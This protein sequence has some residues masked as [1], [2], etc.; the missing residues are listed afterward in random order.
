MCKLLISVVVCGKLYI[1]FHSFSLALWTCISLCGIFSVLHVTFHSFT[2][3]WKVEV[4]HSVTG[5]ILLSCNGTEL[6]SES[7]TICLFVKHSDCYN[8]FW[9]D[10]CFRL[11]MGE[12][13]MQVC[14]HHGLPLHK[15]LLFRTIELIDF[16][17]TPV[18]WLL[19]DRCLSWCSCTALIKDLEE[20]EL[21]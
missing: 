20:L 13:F 12:F 5:D 9:C 11:R 4:L 3:M 16:L 2:L 15:N 1:K 10:C 19:C 14:E 21:V 8:D 6:N 7:C 18:S 17:Y